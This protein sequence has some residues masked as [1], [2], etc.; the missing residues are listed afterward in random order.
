M[1]TYAL[2]L[3]QIIRLKCLFLMEMVCF[4]AEAHKKR[5]INLLISRRIAKLR[6]TMW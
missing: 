3:E 4:Y 2:L 1:F 5:E 6:L